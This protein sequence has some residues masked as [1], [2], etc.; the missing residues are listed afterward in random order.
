MA[1]L[2]KYLQTLKERWGLAHWLVLVLS[3]V[4]V[5]AFGAG[6]FMRDFYERIDRSL[7]PSGMVAFFATAECPTGW[8]RA[9]ELRGR[10][11]VGLDPNRRSDVGKVVGSELGHMENRPAGQHRHTHRNTMPVAGG[12][13]DQMMG[14]GRGGFNDPVENTGTGD[15]AQGE[16]LKPGTN[17]PYI[18]L[19]ACKLGV[20]SQVK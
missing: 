16:P 20:A 14:G 6:V 17:A 4:I 5:G 18:L 1:R 8:L 13:R 12:G 10:Y 11:I 15:A 2:L 3:S 9:D 7:I 19:S